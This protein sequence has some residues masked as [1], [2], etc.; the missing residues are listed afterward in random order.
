M[1]TISQCERVFSRLLSGHKLTQRQAFRWW[2]IMRLGAVVFRI[3]KR[4]G[5]KYIK[6]EL[7]FVKNRYGQKVMVARYSL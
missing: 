6:S 5:Y 2:G 4:Y 3:N 1:K 7:I